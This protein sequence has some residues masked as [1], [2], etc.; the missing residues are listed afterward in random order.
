MA[1][2][3][4]KSPEQMAA[5]R[6]RWEE[7]ASRMM[8][9]FTARREKMDQLAAMTPEER[10]AHWDQVRENKRSKMEEMKQKKGDK[11]ADKRGKKQGRRKMRKVNRKMRRQGRDQN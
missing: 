11:R 5:L 10:K 3:G 6:E 8:T 7:K 1:A 4:K 9:R 2:R